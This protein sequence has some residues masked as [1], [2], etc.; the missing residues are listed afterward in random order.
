MKQKNNSTGNSLLA[1][2][3]ASDFSVAV[4]IAQIVA[5]RFPNYEEA[6]AYLFPNLQH[7]HSPQSMP[8]LQE[9]TEII[10]HALKNKE[11]IL[12]YSHDDV[13]GYTSAVIMYR[14]LQDLYRSEEESVFVYPIIREK[15]GYIVNAEVLQAYKQKGVKHVLTVDFGVSSDEN[16]RI[17]KEA[18]LN[19]VVCDHHETA[20]ANFPVPAIDPKRPDSQYPFRE[21]AG[22][23]VSFKLAQSLYQHVFKLT[24]DE[25]YT[26]K[27]DFFPLVMMGTLS[28]RVML[29]GENRV[30]CTHGLRVLQALQ[31]PW[32]RH[33]LQG[34]ECSFGLVN[35]TIIPIIASAAFS[36]PNLGIHVLMSDDAQHVASTLIR[37]R[38]ITAERRREA[39]VHYKEA[40]A[41][42]KVYP[43][44]VVSVIPFSK[45]QYLG[46]VAA[47][48]RDR[49]NRTSALIGIKDGR[50]FGEFR[51]NN[52]HLYKML[53]QLQRFFLDFGGHP[54]AAGFTMNQDNL[55]SVVAGVVEYVSTCADVLV[56]DTHTVPHQP[57][58]LVNRTDVHMLRALVPFGEGNPP[59]LLTDGNSL[60]TVDNDLH[61]IEMG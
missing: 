34:G 16:F 21:L 24:A 51:S 12:I 30:F 50:C 59:P 39:A 13:D 18:G 57:E 8:D 10:A 11:R 54:R 7:L 40:L 33:F 26:L 42:A 28:D 27:K 15:D 32:A 19:L 43:K 5:N 53:S 37:L 6:R 23:G 4:E 20:T 3:Y 25:F 61:V 44:I 35:S 22:V 31:E 55:D 52:I 36:D 1:Q 14:T 9:T 45:Q 2:K 38:S 56:G 60:Y 29:Q 46:S 17:V 58:A 48:L 49:Y 47:R 41:A